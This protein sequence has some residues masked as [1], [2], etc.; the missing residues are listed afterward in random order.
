MTLIKLSL[1]T[2]EALH[3]GPWVVCSHSLLHCAAQ[4]CVI[5]YPESY[6]H[7]FRVRI[8]TDQFENL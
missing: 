8:V 6:M 4:Y 3:S 1:V 5:S 7:C 2:I